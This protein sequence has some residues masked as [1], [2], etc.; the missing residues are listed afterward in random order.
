MSNVNPTSI[1]WKNSGESLIVALG[2]G[3]VA[4]IDT[5]YNGSVS[6]VI[7]S[8]DRPC[9]GVSFYNFSSK[10]NIDNNNY[11]I[12][13]SSD[14]TVKL[15]DIY[16]SDSPIYN[17]TIPNFPVFSCDINKDGNI[18]CAGGLGGDSKSFIGTPLHIL[19]PF[20]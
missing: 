5:R 3:E 14:M 19:S 8:H 6:K 13:W 17:T 10:S 16:N 11:F 18:A 4:L 7:K 9:Y 2:S 12:S 15:W 20:V 1:S